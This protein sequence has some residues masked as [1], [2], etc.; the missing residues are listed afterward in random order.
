LISNKLE[1]IYKYFWRNF[2]YRKA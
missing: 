1:L 2:A